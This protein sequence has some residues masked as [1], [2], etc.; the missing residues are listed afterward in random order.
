M[1][2]KLYR[3][4]FMLICILCLYGKTEAQAAEKK[5]ANR[6]DGQIVGCQIRLPVAG[7]LYKSK[8]SKKKIAV[9]PRG[10]IL[11]VIKSGNHRFYVKYKKKKGW[12][13]EKHVFVNLVNYIPSID[14]KLHLAK[15]KKLFNIKGKAL[16]DIN[17]NPFY[18]SK[19][20]RQGKQCWLNY[21]AAKKLLKAQR[22]LR[23]DGYSIVLYDAYRPLSVSRKLYKAVSESS[24]VKEM[25]GAVGDYIAFRSAHNKG[26]AVDLTIKDIRTGKELAMPSQIMTLGVESSE[27]SWYYRF[28]KESGNARLLRRYMTQA[29]FLTLSTEWWHFQDGNHYQGTFC[30]EDYYN[31]SQ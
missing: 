12:I 20:V 11:K 23:R 6:S 26:V 17:Q 13:S 10:T 2:R 3:F 7:K 1:K 21:L 22:V 29:G 16:R 24:Y 5:T 15:K 8:K 30:E 27:Q 14:Y 31:I 25:G 18:T 19:G 28:T 9:I 4:C